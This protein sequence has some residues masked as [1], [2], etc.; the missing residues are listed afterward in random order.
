[1]P[2][3]SDDGAEILDNKE[4]TMPVASAVE[5]V[6]GNRPHPATLFR[7]RQGGRH[8]VRLETLLVGGRR[9]TSVEAVRR[10]IQQTTAVANGGEPTASP[11]QKRRREH[12]EAKASL[13]RAGI[14]PR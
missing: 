9:Q 5:R 12:G 1:M 14:L 2:T 3:K 11:T 13:Q 6:T 8:G 7:W 4:A 10:F